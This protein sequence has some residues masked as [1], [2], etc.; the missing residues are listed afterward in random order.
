MIWDENKVTVDIVASN[1]QIITAII[2]VKDQ[3]Q[4]LMSMV[5]ASLNVSFRHQLWSYL[6]ELGKIVHVPWMLLGNFN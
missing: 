4:M 3:F 5:Y 2:G 6:R 1:E